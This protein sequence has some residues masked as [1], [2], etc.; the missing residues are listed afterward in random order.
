MCH[1]GRSGTQSISD[2]ILVIF[3]LVFGN[4]RDPGK[5]HGVVESRLEAGT[6]PVGKRVLSDPAQCD[7]CKRL[8]RFQAHIP[9]R[10]VLAA[11]RA[12]SVGV[13]VEREVP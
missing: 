12:G 10:P 1:K 9:L 13:R 7:A 5:P 8:G 4:I 6:Y 2:G 11:S 3:R